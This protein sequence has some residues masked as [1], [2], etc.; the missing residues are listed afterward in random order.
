MVPPLWKT[1]QWLLRKLKLEL[2]CDPT[3]PL[4]GIH[5][6][7]LKAGSPGDICTPMLIEHHSQQP[8]GGRD[9]I[10]RRQMDG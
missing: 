2:P 1:A 6:K 7:E 3:I 4:L 5:P 10:V 8:K 9:P